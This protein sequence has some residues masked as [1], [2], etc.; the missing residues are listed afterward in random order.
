MRLQ[1]QLR[2]Q[3]HIELQLCY[4]E[5][6]ESKLAIDLLKNSQPLL[7]VNK[8]STAILRLIEANK[9]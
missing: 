3:L 8:V 6:L 7:S 2:Q 5:F 9:T 1:E 4:R